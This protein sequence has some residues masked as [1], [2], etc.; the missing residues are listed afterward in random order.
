MQ[1]GLK[2]QVVFKT[3]FTHVVIHVSEL[4]IEQQDV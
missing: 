4:S 1:S 3:G 2:R